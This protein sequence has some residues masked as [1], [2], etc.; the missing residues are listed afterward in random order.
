MINLNWL[1]GLAG[2]IFASFALGSLRDPSNRKRWGNACFWALLALS[3]WILLLHGGVVFPFYVI[4]LLPFMALNIAV[5]LNAP[6]KWLTRRVGF[7]L[8]RV[9]LL[10]SL[11][12][13]LVPFNV[14][15]ASPLFALHPTSAQSDALL[16][17]RN[18]V[19]HNAVVITDST[20]YTDLH[21]A[22]GEGVADGTTYPYAHIYWN[23][24][25]DPKIYNGLLHED[26][27]A[28][29]YIVADTKMLHDIKTS[30]SAMLVLNRALHHSILRVEFRADNGSQP[31]SPTVIQIYQIIHIAKT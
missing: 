12:V 9:L 21:E 2:V 29:D 3:F 18:N 14:Q 1:Y 30:D 4:P 5:A 26:W 19:P 6:L 13:A 8:V 31:A 22:G 25:H 20:F 27:N 15:L 17:I 16:W 24:V 11:I 28:I 10:F 23:V 7:D